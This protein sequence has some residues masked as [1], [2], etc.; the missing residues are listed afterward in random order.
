MPE[1]QT[2][3]WKFS[4]RDEHLKSVCG[5][6]NAVGGTLVIGRDDAGKPVGLPDARLLLEE[7]PNKLRDLLGIMAEVNLREQD[8]RECLEIVVPAYPNPISYRGR[9]YQRSGS[10]LQE[11]KGAALDRFLLRRYGRTWDGSPLPG[12]E[13][14]DLS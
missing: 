1:S 13:A 9:Y 11:L 3:E 14:A 5:F 7:L 10:T 6:A 12:L 4:W 2:L 8:G